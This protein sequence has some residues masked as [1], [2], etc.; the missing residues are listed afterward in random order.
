VETVPDVAGLAGFSL[1]E[2]KFWM[3]FHIVSIGCELTSPFGASSDPSAPIL[4]SQQR[5]IWR[6][7]RDH[8]A[9][10]VQCFQTQW[11]DLHLCHV[12]ARES[13]FLGS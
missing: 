13:I 4:P 12:F 1:H 8:S 11:S 7:V 9:E 10:R 2:C 6:H 5:R 3:H